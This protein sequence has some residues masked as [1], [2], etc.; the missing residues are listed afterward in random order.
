MNAGVA[1]HRADTTAS[2]DGYLKRTFKNLLTRI[3]LVAM[4]LSLL[5][6]R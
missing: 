3:V 6:I 2:G 4:L 5:P 1:H